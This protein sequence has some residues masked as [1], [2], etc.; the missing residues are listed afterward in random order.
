[1]KS[2]VSATSSSL[3][4]AGKL[5]CRSK[6]SVD[7][8]ISDTL[9]AFSRSSLQEL[10]DLLEEEPANIF[11][12]LAFARKPLEYGKPKAA[13]TGEEP[14]HNTYRKMYSIPKE[15]AQEVI[16]SYTDENIMDLHTFTACEKKEEGVSRNV[17]Y[18]L[19][20]IGSHSPWPRFCHDRSV[21]RLTFRQVHAHHGSRALKIATK[22]SD[23]EPTIDWTRFGACVI[24]PAEGFPKT[25][26][27][28]VSGAK[29]RGENRSGGYRRGDQRRHSRLGHG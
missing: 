1:M 29:L 7:N 27:T 6:K 2:V 19:H 17:F 3:S 14:F 21:F 28:H 5:R 20:N 26:L 22:L 23:G 10:V 16:T 12:A 13:A 4:P 15:F 24:E 18:F 8:C 25:H 11:P 9:D